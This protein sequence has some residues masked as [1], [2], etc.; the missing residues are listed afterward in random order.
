VDNITDNGEPEIIFIFIEQALMTQP[1][2][3]IVVVGGGSGSE[4]IL[5]ESLLL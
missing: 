2:K 5:H 3:I 4:M 1:C